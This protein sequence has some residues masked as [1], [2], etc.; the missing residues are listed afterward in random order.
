M[1]TDKYSKA[2]LSQAEK[3]SKACTLFYND[4][5]AVPWFNTICHTLKLKASQFFLQL[6]ESAEFQNF[7][8]NHKE[9][10]IPHKEIETL[11]LAFILQQLKLKHLE[12]FSKIITDIIKLN[13]A[14]SRVQDTG[15]QE[16]VNLSYPAEYVDSEYATDL[17]FFVANV[18]PKSSKIEI[19]KQRGQ[20]QFRKI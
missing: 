6:A 8:K 11:Q 20:I 7:V 3:I 12:K 4:G 15:K 9:V 13:G 10:C 2:D 16:I 5:R 17:Q 19:Y 18:R 1:F 14:I